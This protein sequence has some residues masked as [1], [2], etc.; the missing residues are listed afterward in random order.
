MIQLYGRLSQRLCEE[1]FFQN[2]IFH[3][4]SHFLALEDYGFPTI[5]TKEVN[6]N[7][8]LAPNVALLSIHGTFPG[9]PSKGSKQKSLNVTLKNKV[10]R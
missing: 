7:Q 10:S 4:F 1:T 5:H 3:Y 6:S 9:S 8:G 2:I